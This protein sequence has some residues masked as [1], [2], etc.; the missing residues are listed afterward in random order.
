[1]PKRIDVAVVD[2][3]PNLSDFS[4]IA[5]RELDRA[6]DQLER[7]AQSSANDIDDT[8][9]RLGREIEDVF[10]EIAE[11]GT[12]DMQTLTS[13]A[14]RVATEM[15]QDFQREG[16]VAEDA[17]AELRRTANRNLDQIDRNVALTT[18]KARGHFSALGLVGSA[19]LLGVG[20]AATAGL[21]A[22]A[23]MGLQSAAALE[24]T[25]VSFDALLG[26]A[27]K[28]REVF[29]DLQHFAAVTPFEFQD[30]AAAAKRFLAF[31]EQVGISDDFL[32]QFLTVVGDLASVTGAGAE[33]LNR[34][35]LAIGQI[36]SKGKVQL[37]ELM[38]ISEAV[39]G[40][41]A[42]GAIAQA[43]GIST[44]EAMQRISAGAVD[45]RTGIAALLKG[46]QQFPG[47][48]GAMEKQSQTLL[49]VFSTFK[50]TVSIALADA[51]AP[52][53][54]SIKKSLTEATPLIGEAL[55][56]LAPA[57]G[58]LIAG[59]LP[60]VT[61]LIKLIE[62]VLT[63]LLAALADALKDPA[64]QTAMSELGK[65]LGEI[66]VAL[67]P[68]I[69]L[70]GNF[71]VA[72]LEIAVPL[73]QLLVP[74][75]QLL[76][77]LLQFLADAVGEF[78]KWLDTVNWGDV[79]DDI[80]GGFTDAW[81]AVV[82]FFEGIGNFF[83]KLPSRVMSFISSL[84][85]RLFT[86]INDMFDRVLQSIGV[87]IGLII[88]V[89]TRFPSMALNAL[90]NMPHLV[91][92]FFVNM[93]NDA[94]AQFEEFVLSAGRFIDE[95]P[96][97]VINGLIQLGVTI[98]TFFTNAF[99]RAKEIA[100]NTID[101]IVSFVRSIPSRIGDFALS[102]GTSIV[103]FFKTFLNRAIDG[104]NAGIAKVDALIPGDLPRIPRLAHGGIAFGPA[105][106]GED[107]TTG[108]E[109]AIPLGDQRALDLLR[110]ALGEGG[111]TVTFAPGAIVVNVQGTITADQAGRV[112]RSIGDGIAAALA[113]RDVRTAVRVA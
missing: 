90:V 88:A 24:Q 1:M 14:D 31:N 106:I 33:G 51:F 93:F 82:N 5:N 43:M 97:R 68:I 79:G 76:T 109:A 22:L 108:P 49:G 35:T 62:P 36:A 101:S 8:Y 83:A 107:S 96:G 95:L 92:D 48:A 54:P 86:F 40:F 59:L 26:S 105:L 23:A 46:M 89:F 55:G 6:F 10:N 16:E 30:V 53:I 102:I 110:D 58:S 60:V 25:Q 65:S 67:V 50:D 103:N 70:L 42:I 4:R 112:G 74:A 111:Q 44:A 2:I 27:E 20:A 12:V 57:L 78:A 91:R 17:F 18:T 66:A 77:P 29:R 75:F 41:S 80:A 37:E 52:V 11:T 21:G 71:L 85:G 94:K 13:V 84:P 32:Q 45:A 56:S 69:P 9:E 87:Q 3:I 73:T 38:Q 28:G 98:A 19:A 63:P 113:R 34:I 81:D 72:L 100:K 39:P 99:N 61:G 7:T 15:A 47:A 104:L 64:I